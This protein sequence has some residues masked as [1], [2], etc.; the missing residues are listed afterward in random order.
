[1]EYLWKYYLHICI[2]LL[3][4]SLYVY[5]SFYQSLSSLLCFDDYTNI[6]LKNLSKSFAEFANRNNSFP[7]LT[8]PSFP[9]QSLSHSPNLLLTPFPQLHFN[10]CKLKLHT[11]WP[12]LMFFSNWLPFTHTHQVFWLRPHWNIVRCGCHFPEW[13]WLRNTV[14][15]WLKIC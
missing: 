3:P 12:N 15:M 10:V 8:L 11:W 5:L 2:F 13:K 9:F 4:P 1:M 6:F 7:L 14:L